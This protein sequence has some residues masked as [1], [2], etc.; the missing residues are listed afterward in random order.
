[1][2]MCLSMILLITGGS[3]SGK[4]EFAENLAVKQ[5]SSEL[6]YIAT[7]MPQDNESLQRIARHQEQ[8]RDKGFKTLECYT[9][10]QGIRLENSPVVLLEC[11]SNLLANEMYSE[12]GFVHKNDNANKEGNANKESNIN[13]E[14]NAYKES[15]VN[16]D[17]AIKDRDS[18]IIEEIINGITQLEQVC[19]QVII[20][21]NE[22]FSDN[23]SIYEETNRYIKL[24]GEIN[25]RIAMKADCVYEVV[26]GIPVC[27]KGKIV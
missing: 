18:L 21:S 5:K 19:K 4:S 12:D 25:C 9:D 14:S 13:K 8:R 22:V 1:M 26:C 15:N 23:G 11:M 16:N 2:A 3:G 20:V 10:L 24:L 17:G 27:Q 6:L 7:M